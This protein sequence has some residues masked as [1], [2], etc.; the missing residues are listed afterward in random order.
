VRVTEIELDHAV[1]SGAVLRT[2]GAGMVPVFE[3]HTARLERNI[4]L[5]EWETMDPFEK[6]LI[7]AQR[8]IGI[9]L[10][11]LQAEAQIKAAKLKGARKR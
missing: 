1:S 5:E 10:E 9:A 8:R 11:N 4:R 6:A 3:E 2:L 7:I